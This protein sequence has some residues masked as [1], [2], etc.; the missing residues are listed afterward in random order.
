MSPA[1]NLVTPW[2]NSCPTT[3]SDVSGVLAPDT[4]ICPGESVTLRLTGVEGDTIYWQSN[5]NGGGFT[6]FATTDTL[7]QTQV[8]T[9]TDSTDLNGPTL[10]MIVECILGCDPP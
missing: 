4:T 1:L 5:V 8:V 3:S 6:T 9:P 10:A 2:V 7:T